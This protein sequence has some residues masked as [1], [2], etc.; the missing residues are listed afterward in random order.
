MGII[1]DLQVIAHYVSYK[2]CSNYVD[3][4]FNKKKSC[5]ATL[6]DFFSKNL[7]MTKIL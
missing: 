4:V 6:S 1:K 3:N 5:L 7:F 2:I